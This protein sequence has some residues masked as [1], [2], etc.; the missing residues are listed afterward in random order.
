[1]SDIPGLLPRRAA[2]K[3]LDAVLRRGETMEQA[4]GAA[5]GL[6]GFADRAL[7]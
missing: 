3:M 1:M 5:N 2:L 7:A 4:G 6:P